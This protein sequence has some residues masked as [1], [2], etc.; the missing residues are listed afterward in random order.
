MKFNTCTGIALA[1]L[2][3]TQLGAT[4]YSELKRLVPVAATDPIP[5]ADFVRAPVF[6]SPQLSY[7][8]TY[9]AA[10]VSDETDHTSLITYDRTTQTI[11][12]I[13]SKGDQ[14]VNTF[15][16]LGDKRLVYT[17]S[18][19]KVQNTNLY[20]GE[21]GQLSNSLPLFL[22]VGVS[23]FAVP[24]G[25]RSHPLAN[26]FAD[27][28]NTGHFDDAV[29]INT[30]IM[31]DNTGVP[32][33]PRDA[34]IKRILERYPEMKT[35]HGFDRGFFA[36]KE[37]KLA[38]GLTQEDGIISLQILDGDK[39][40]KCPE[41]MDQI[42]LVSAGDNP[43][44][45]T[46]IGPRNGTTPR[47]LEFMNAETGKE[48][49]VLLQDKSYDFNGWLFRDPASHNIVGVVY[50]KAAPT[51]VWFTQAYRDLQK[52]VDALFPGQVVRILG[53]DDAGKILLISSGTD[54]QPAV[55]SW[56][57]LEKHASGLIHNS[58]PWIDPKRM[59]PTGI[60]KYK[61]AEGRM[62]D[63]YITL[64]AG[65]TK[66]NPPPMVVL[67]HPFPNGRTVWQY[68]ADVQFLASRGYA[69]LQPNYRGS[70]GYSWMFP[71]ED[72]WEFRKM[73]D[74]VTSA[75][76][77]VIAMGLVDGKRVAIMGTYFAGYLAA[78]GAAYEP[79]LYKCAISISGAYFDWGRYIKENKITQFSN[80][81][82][83]RYLRKLGDPNKNPQKFDAMAPLKHADQ[84]TSALFVS[85][86][87]YD[88]PEL[89][90]QS[91]DF[92]SAVERN[93][94]QVETMSFLDE[95]AGVNHFDHKLDLYKHIEAFLAK[96][97]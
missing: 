17:V 12:G 36:D 14:D 29:T 52:A 47:A 87:E 83:S 32:A 18:F 63:A 73:S 90:S 93:H 39:W 3:S 79:G 27:G 44:D 49:D 41:D 10:I 69:V 86:G 55:Y 48:G 95:A 66:A 8:G 15:V 35:D 7:T 84:V 81:F 54:R 13:G 16:W 42:D 97:L 59:R 58:E 74:D 68:Y 4:E 65:A 40:V 9:V 19:A 61:T 6:Q 26:L 85:W 75:T 2:A 23:V 21:A 57:D 45:V 30:A 67:P 51:V 70:A 38:Y 50:N 88:D 78:S 53:M 76:K 71:E 20:V 60:I 24:P 1:C 43:G 94:V 72:E 96:N 34:N 62:L 91:K 77:A 89:I 31:S 56:V 64:P 5:V 33:G 82:Y 11:D 80:A 46:V 92:A 28:I 37:G 25:D 22:N